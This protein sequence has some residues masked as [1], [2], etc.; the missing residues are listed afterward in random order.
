MH[1]W[2]I[3][4]AE[5]T[6]STR[7]LYGGTLDNAYKKK[8][9]LNY[10]LHEVDEWFVAVKSINMIGD[11]LSLLLKKI[12]M[13]MTVTVMSRH[14]MTLFFEPYMLSYLTK[15]WKIKHFTRKIKHCPVYIGKGKYPNIFFFIFH[16][17]LNL[18]DFNWWF[19]TQII[20]PS[21]GRCCWKNLLFTFMLATGENLVL[22]IT[23]THHF[24]CK[25]I[26]THNRYLS[27]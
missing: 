18:I 1:V 25:N 19:L 27:A 7:A 17:Q 5:V 13:L 22:L 8:M 20:G 21:F 15:M 2:L 10:L 16:Y 12:Q 4:V 6:S 3:H 26:L 9:Y 11:N 14:A 24:I 23:Q